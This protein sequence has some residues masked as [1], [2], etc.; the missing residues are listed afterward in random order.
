MSSGE[1]FSEFSL[2]NWWSRAQDWLMKSS[3]VVGESLLYAGLAEVDETFIQFSN[4]IVVDLREWFVCV[5]ARARVQY[6]F[7]FAPFVLKVVL[8]SAKEGQS[9]R[10]NI[11]FHLLLASMLRYMHIQLWM[12]VTRFHCLVKKYKIQTNGVTF[13]QKDRE[14]HW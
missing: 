11:W 13:E 10:D 1:I 7:A 9:L 4:K 12:S 5:C 14:R 2:E 8:Q 6:A 3:R